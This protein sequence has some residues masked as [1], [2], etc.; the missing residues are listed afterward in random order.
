MSG[1]P[2]LLKAHPLR[3]FSRS[4]ER[5]QDELKV[6]TDLEQARRAK[7]HFDEQASAVHQRL[8]SFYGGLEV[9]DQRLGECQKQIA[10]LTR[11]LATVERQIA[12]AK[13][14]QWPRPD[15]GDDH[16]AWM[17]QE[18]SKARTEVYIKA[19]AL[20]QQA[21]MGAAHQLSLIHI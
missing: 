10:T 11:Q 14:I 7:Q 12:E 4:R 8:Q 18:W 20:H 1:S 15:I 6:R 19:L 13:Q 9:G 3:S 5:Q 17:D 21:V 16:V 2:V